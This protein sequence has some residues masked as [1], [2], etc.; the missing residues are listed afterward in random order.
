MQ[1]EAF[2]LQ[3]EA[4]VDEGLGAV[5]GGGEG[6]AGE[7]ADAVAEPGGIVLDAVGAFDCGAG[8]SG[9]R[10][11]RRSRRGCRCRRG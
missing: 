8:S 1:Q 6:R 3:G 4:F 2:G 11:A 9:S 7:G 10:Q 5:A